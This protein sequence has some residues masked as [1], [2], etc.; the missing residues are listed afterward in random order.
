MPPARNRRAQRWLNLGIC[1][2]PNHRG[3]THAVRHHPSDRLIFCRVTVGLRSPLGASRSAGVFVLAFFVVEIDGEGCENRLADGRIR[4]LP[5][6][7]QTPDDAVEPLG[8]RR[9]GTSNRILRD[10]SAAS[11]NGPRIALS[12]GLRSKSDCFGCTALYG[13]VSATDVK[14]ARMSVAI[15][16]NSDIVGKPSISSMVFTM[17]CCA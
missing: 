4:P 9:V 11:R 3:A 15:R 17:L 16:S 2:T 6:V 12:F 5:S 1:A 10:A 13:L 8:R 14:L 7:H